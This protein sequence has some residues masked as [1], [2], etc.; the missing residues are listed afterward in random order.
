MIAIEHYHGVSIS[1]STTILGSPFPPLYHHLEEMKINVSSDPNATDLDKK[2]MD[3]LYYFT[4]FGWPGSIY[5]DVK[6]LLSR[7]LIVYDKLWAV[8]KPGD[9]VVTRDPIGIFTLA[10]VT[11][12]KY[13]EHPSPGRTQYRWW[14]EL[15]TISQKNGQFRKFSVRNRLEKFAGARKIIELDF[16]PLKYH[17]RADELMEEALVRGRKWKNF[18]EGQTKV[19]NYEGEALP[20]I[21]AETAFPPRSYG[22]DIGDD[23]EINSSK[24]NRQ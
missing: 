3:A 1:E 12:V 19:M 24:V 5:G 22:S 21:L 9:L 8:F 6:N 4:K 15:V 14:V 11:S 13:E 16:Y 10:E 7:G 17:D 20:I 2:H 23:T 18:I